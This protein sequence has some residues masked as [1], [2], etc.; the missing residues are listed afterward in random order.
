M[1]RILKI[2]AGA[3]MLLLALGCA[4][5]RSAKPAAQAGGVESWSAA[6]CSRARAVIVRTARGREG[7]PYVYG[8]RGPSSFDCSGFTV[9]AYKAAGITLKPTAAQQ[10]TQGT[11]I[12]SNK[13]LKPGDLVFF[14]GKK[15]QGTVSHVGIVVKYNSSDR[16]FTFIH[17]PRSG[18]E[19]QESTNSYYR[20]RYLGARRI[21][22]R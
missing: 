13:P 8:G 6:E 3:L 10:Y 17:A 16:T 19:L 2:A 11:Y 20:R 1:K 14:G 15:D 18:V 9:Y 4:A 5:T 22:P 21:L 7:C 12:S